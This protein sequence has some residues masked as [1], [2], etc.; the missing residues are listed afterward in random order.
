MNGTKSVYGVRETLAELRTLDKKAQL[1][2]QREMKSAA[3]PLANK[4]AAYLP[5]TA[6]LSGFDHLGRTGWNDAA[7]WDVKI[8]YGGRKRKDANEWPLLSLRLESAQAMIFDMAGRKTTN[9]LGSKL[10]ARFGSASRAAWRPAAELF[11]ETAKAITEALEKATKEMNE[12]LVYK[13]G[14]VK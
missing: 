10:S 5:T 9:L 7:I 2:C 11:E 8:K 3:K 6:P 1:A 12:N 4:I 13:S 14:A